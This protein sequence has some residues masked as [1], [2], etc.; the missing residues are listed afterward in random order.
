[1]AVALAMRG[2]SRHLWGI[3]IGGAACGREGLQYA[4]KLG[5]WVA[6]IACGSE[7]AE[8]SARFGADYYSDSAAEDPGA[9]L[10]KL[11]GAA[12]IIAAG[13]GRSMSPLIGGLVPGAGWW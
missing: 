13:S 4:A 2:S 12:A 3:F 10:C 11:G 5:Y 8:L 1:M 9:A 6:A 7:K